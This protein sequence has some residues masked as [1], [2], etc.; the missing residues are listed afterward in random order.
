[1][2]G[3]FAV[4]VWFVVICLVAWVVDRYVPKPEPLQVVWRV[5]VAIFA[6]WYLLDVF[7]LVNGPFP[8]IR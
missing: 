3:I 8:S 1:M 6:V 7:G 2:T 5:G 4:I